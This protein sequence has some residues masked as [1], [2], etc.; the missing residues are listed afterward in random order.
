MTR[1][2]FLDQLKQDEGNPLVKRAIRK[3]Q[4]SAASASASAEFIRRR[5]RPWC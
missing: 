1:Q 5:R 3:A 4:R 2:E